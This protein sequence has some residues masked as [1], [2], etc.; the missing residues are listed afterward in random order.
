MMWVVA[1][2]TQGTL[3]RS[4]ALWASLV[5]WEWGQTLTYC[6]RFAAWVMPT[7]KSSPSFILL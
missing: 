1:S 6:L 5:F 3:G 2:G 7:T 4:M